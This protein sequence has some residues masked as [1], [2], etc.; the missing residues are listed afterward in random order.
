[1]LAFV[2]YIN[3]LIHYH[4]IRFTFSCLKKLTTSINEPIE[5]PRASPR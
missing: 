2:V 4:W 3:H 5:L 1:L